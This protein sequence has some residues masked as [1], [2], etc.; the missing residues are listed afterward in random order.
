M[1]PI[2]PIISASRR[3]DIPAFYGDW[4][5]QMVQ[6]GYVEVSNPFSG[7]PT[8][9]SLDPDKVSAIVFWSKNYQPFLDILKQIESR[10]QHRFLFHFTINGF[11]NNA[12]KLFEPKTPEFKTA[13]ETARHLANRYG[14]EKVIWRFDPIIFS[15]LTPASER[16]DTFAQIAQMLE[17][18]VSRCY[19]SFVDLYKKV[20]RNFE[21]LTR[22]ENLQFF[23]P[24]LIE[25]VQFTRELAS[26]AARHGIEV[27]TCCEDEIA[28][29]A[30]ITRGHCIDA[31]LLQKLYP[32]QQFSTELRPTR[33]GCGC[34]A[35]SDIGTY[36]T[37]QHRC[38]YC[39]ANN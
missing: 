24:S 37:C 10:Y 8:R 27:M 21:K 18:T 34:Y 1:S 4:F 31:K 38:I 23:K 25:Q 3:T 19:I 26:L 5:Y 33:K 30:G 7:K 39:Y 32:D 11:Q 22:Q 2:L 13:V 29:A 9:I 16:L 17:Q 20:K 28:T 36:N 14:K 12:K 35:S 15:N 6:Q